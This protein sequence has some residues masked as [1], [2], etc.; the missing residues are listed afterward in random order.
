MNKIF[1]IVE[2]RNLVQYQSAHPGSNRLCDFTSS[3]FQHEHDHF[4]QTL[5]PG[6]IE[7]D[8]NITTEKD[9]LN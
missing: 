4:Y 3:V 7:S 1:K 2:L 5:F 9:D 6:R 8:K